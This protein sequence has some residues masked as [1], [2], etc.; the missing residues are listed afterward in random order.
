MA[1]C[2]GLP[3]DLR[4]PRLAVPCPVSLCILKGTAAGEDGVLSEGGR[5]YDDT[6]R[7]VHAAKRTVGRT[8]TTDKSWPAAG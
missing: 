1:G 7:D 3:E 8:C 2:S 5:R 4:Q 6:Q